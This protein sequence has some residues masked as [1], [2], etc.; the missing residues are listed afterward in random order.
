MKSFKLISLQIVS[1]Q[2]LTDIEFVDGL[3]INKENSSNSWIVEALV[4]SNHFNEL[5]KILP[6]DNGEVMIQAVITKQDNDPALFKTVLKINTLAD[7]YIS[8]LF[9]GKL[10]KARN[11]YAEVLLE[12]L[13]QQGFAGEALIQEFKEKLRSK[14]KIARINKES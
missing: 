6:D 2:Q 3:I 13:V 11:Q 12:N 4:S 5:K 14:R 9:V 1:N 10:Q 7:G 8:L